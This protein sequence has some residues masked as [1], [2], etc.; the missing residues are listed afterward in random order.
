VVSKIELE[1]GGEDSMVQA[2]MA[3]SGRSRSD[4]GGGDDGDG[5]EAEVGPF[6]VDLSGTQLSGSVT[7][8]FDSDVPDGTYHELQIAVGP[9]TGAAAGS[10]LADMQGSSIVV[11]GSLAAAGGSTAGTPF[12]FRS[13][14]EAKQ[15]L[16][17]TIVVDKTAKSSN[18]T[19]ALPLAQWFAGPN[20]TTLDPTADANRAAIEA[21]IRASLRFDRDDDHN[22]E[23]DGPGH[24]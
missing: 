16:E 15:K 21:N 22:G 24:H 17:T 2:A 20:G 9:V 3:P 5:S 23:D 7:E 12:S 13:A 6:L 11:E 1:T 8:V 4:D 10:P 19:L 18:V 14:L